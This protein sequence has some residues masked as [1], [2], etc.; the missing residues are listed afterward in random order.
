MA[1][2]LSQREVVIILVPFSNLR[3]FKTRPAIVAS[4]DDYNKKFQDFIAIPLT[5]NLKERQHVVKITKKEMESGALLQDS[6]A[7]IDKIFSVDQSLI[8]I[9]IGKIKKESF[10]EIKKMLLDL[11]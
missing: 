8:K 11:I 6:N 2:F 4:K 10:N 1:N 7:K 3:Q 9:K 5:S